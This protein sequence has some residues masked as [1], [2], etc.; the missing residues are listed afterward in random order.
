MKIKIVTDSTCDLPREMI[1]AEDIT[2]VP[3]YINF[4]E[5]SYRDGVDISRSDFYEMLPKA[6]V[7]PTTSVPGIGVFVR[8]YQNL[9]DAGADHII[10]IHISSHLSNTVTCESCS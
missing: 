5:E 6:E 1:E 7:Q 8:A 3:L 2:V 10:S 4:G 9:I